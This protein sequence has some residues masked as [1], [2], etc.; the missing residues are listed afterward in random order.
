LL[1]RLIYWRFLFSLQLSSLHQTMQ[2]RNS[3]L[4]WN[5]TT[6]DRF[7]MRFSNALNSREREYLRKARKC[8]LAI[9]VF[10]I[11]RSF[12][13]QRP[14][15]L[16]DYFDIKAV[17]IKSQISFF[18][19]ERKLTNWLRWMRSSDRQQITFSFSA[20]FMRYWLNLSAAKHLA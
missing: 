2:I 11:N 7:W 10:Q 17:F 4:N 20:N 13:T 6:L 16:I 1:P 9:N 19:L 8:Y 12:I 15:N 14:K 3:H 5:N 18:F